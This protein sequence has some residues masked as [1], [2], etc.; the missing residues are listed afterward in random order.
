MAT[1]GQ[2]SARS[3]SKWAKTK[4]KDGAGNGNGDKEYQAIRN[5]WWQSC[6]SGRNQQ[7]L[8]EGIQTM[9]RLMICQEDELA[10]LRADR[11]Y[12][13]YM[14]TKGGILPN[15]L[16]FLCNGRRS[17]RRTRRNMTLIVIL[18]IQ[19]WAHL[20]KTVQDDNLRKIAQDAE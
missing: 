9:G 14:D 13:L 2:S 8:E 7:D 3:Q 11:G 15:R 12:I 17:K 18:L 20:D 10:Q 4:D 16:E 19:W 6:K 5:Q 1:P